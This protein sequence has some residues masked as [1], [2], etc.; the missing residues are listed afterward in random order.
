MKDF[1]PRVP[2]QE[3]VALLEA[4]ID[5][6]AFLQLFAAALETE[7]LNRADVEA[8]L[9][10][11]PITEVGVAQGSLLSTLVGNLSLRD[12]DAR[13]NAEGLITIRYLDDFLILAPDLDAAQAGFARAQQELARLN[14]SCYTPGDGSQKAALGLVKE[15]FNFLGCHLHPDGVSPAR[16]SGR[17]LVKE[18]GQ[19]IARGT[20]NIR[21]FEGSGQRRRT[22][23]AYVQTLAQIDRKIRGW[24]DVYQFVSNRLPFSQI[25]DQ[26]DRRLNQFHAWFDR[27]YNLSDGRARRRMRGVAL[28]ADTPKDNSA[29]TSGEKSDPR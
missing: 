16:S 23:S 5:D 22:E 11:F 2:R 29:S 13:M 12:F 9:A 14:M 20:K 4:N 1:F 6:P 15:G 18:I 24:G 7:I 10:L 28:L 26:I 27:S 8:W 3:V 17:R 21:A 25:D 19:I